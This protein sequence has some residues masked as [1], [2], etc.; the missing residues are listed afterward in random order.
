ML[1]LTL[2]I[3]LIA[4]AAS[5]K[6]VN[7]VRRSEDIWEKCYRDN[8]PFRKCRPKDC[9]F[10]V[11]I[12]LERARVEDMKRVL[13]AEDN[14]EQL[15]RELET[16][17][18]CLTTGFN[19][20]PAD[21]K[22]QYKID[23]SL[24]EELLSNGVTFLRDVCDPEVIDRIRRNLDCVME[25]SV[26]R[27]TSRCGRPNLD[28]N[29]SGIEYTDDNSAAISACYDEKYRRNCDVVGVIDCTSKKVAASCNQDAGDIVE[30][31]YDAFYNTLGYPMCPGRNMKTLLEYFKK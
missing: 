25:E 13:S 22:E 3:V 18:G 10:P 24:T 23:I 2:I 28:K 16:L 27:A 1:R 30:F 9:T 19:E 20:S 15:C 14:L 21:C 11:Y 5:L 12:A 29:C 7:K 31:L 6:H 8:H 26:M 4:V 17:L